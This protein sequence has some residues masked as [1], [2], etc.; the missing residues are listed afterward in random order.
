MAH[1]LLKDNGAYDR[2]AIARRAN[3]ALR[4]AFSET[5]AAEQ[6]RRLQSETARHD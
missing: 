3:S 5:R 6:F 1:R 2:A 4:R